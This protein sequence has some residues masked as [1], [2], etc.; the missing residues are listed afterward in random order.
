[1]TLVA[2]PVDDSIESAI[3]RYRLAVPARLRTLTIWLVWRFESA[4]RAG[5]KPLKVPYYAGSGKRRSGIQGAPDDLAQLVTFDQALDALRSERWTGIGLAHVPGCGLNSWDFDNVIDDTGSLPPAL[6][7]VLRDADTYV[8]VSP[9]GRGVRMIAL[10]NLPS[11]KRIHPGGHNIECFG[12]SGFVTVTGHILCGEEVN[13]LPEAVDKI[14]REWL[15][16]DVIERPHT[17]LDQLAVVRAADPVYQ[18]LKTASA[19]KRDWPDGRSSIVCPFEAEHTSGSGRSDT[20]Y[21]A[22][23]T[24]GY[25]AGHFKCL[26]AHCA[27]RSDADFVAALGVPVVDFSGLLGN[28]KQPGGLLLD[29]AQ[30]R[31]SVGSLRWLVKHAVPAN[32]IG[33]LYGPSGSFKSFIA[34]DLA[35]HIAHGLPWLG[36]KTKAGPV[37]YVA[38]EG[39][40][41]LLGRI[42]AWHQKHGI[43]PPDNLRVCIVP[44]M[45]DVPRDLARLSDAIAAE[46]AT[47]GMP[48]VLIVLDTMSQTMNGDENE[49]RDTAGYLR[50]LSLA[51][52]ARFEAAVM[53]VHHTGHSTAD[54]PRGSSVIK[55]NVDFL[56]SVTRPEDQMVAILECRKQKDGDNGAPLPFVLEREI[57]GTDDDGDE[58]TSLVASHHDSAKA[59]VAKGN[60]R[61]TRHEKLLLECIGNGR[62]YGDVRDDFYAKLGEEKPDTKKKAFARAFKALYECGS[63]VEKG[64]CVFSTSD[65]EGGT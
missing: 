54:R 43:A 28:D 32:S 14:L 19:I 8:E 39:G 33:I 47:L 38:A 48:P 17:R 2:V 58:L 7:L 35:L 53:P 50:G 63:I 5:D 59:I 18:A 41:G 16:A 46:C 61:T 62:L 15:Q 22:P 55:G 60:E 49:A 26:H 1:M 13:P 29:V 3:E 44:L 45:L 36:R 4:A 6:E 56:F 64:N 65:N 42:D 10:G 11:I 57:V 27:Q 30:L 20:V 23:N 31:A 9:S 51:L 24:N 21:F 52:R 12:E 37:I 25:A 40:T 34:L